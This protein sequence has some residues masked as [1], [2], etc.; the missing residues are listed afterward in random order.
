MGTSPVRVQLNGVHATPLS[1]AARG[2]SK[3]HEGT[4]KSLYV[5]FYDAGADMGAPMECAAYQSFS[6]S[7]TTG[8][9]NFFG[10]AI[11]NGRFSY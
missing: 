4:G 8:T 6:I 10:S 3:I 1:I 11:S 2:S 9:L 5:L 7:P